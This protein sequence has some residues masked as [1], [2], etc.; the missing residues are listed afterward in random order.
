MGSLVLI[1]WP[2]TAWSAAGR[3]AGRTPLALTD[4]GKAQAAF[5]AEGLAPQGLDAVLCSDEQTSRE[6]AGIVAD[7]CNTGH[8]TVE[9]LAEVDCGLWDGLTV[10]ELKR[11]YPK[12]FKRWL[13]DPSSVCPPEGED[14][15]GAF[16]RI[17]TSIEQIV[18]KQRTRNIALVLGPLVFGLAR[19]VVENVDPPAVRS[20]MYDQPLRYA[21]LDDGERG[22]PVGLR[23]WA[24][25][26][27]RQ[28][29]SSS[30]GHSMERRKRPTEE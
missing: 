4:Q 18:R 14:L 9:S 23:Q 13:S 15:A 8:K 19:C 25:E 7:R 27:A 11:R 29:V 26:R 12:I 22:S 5:W 24:K 20:M 28:A 30:V 16:T 17:K 6:T 1:P 10:D 21:L 3:I 2:E